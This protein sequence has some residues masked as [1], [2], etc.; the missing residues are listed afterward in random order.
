MITLPILAAL[1]AAPALTPARA[2]I[3]PPNVPTLAK[4][5]AVDPPLKDAPVQTIKA[6]MRVAKPALHRATTEM[7]S[8]HSHRKHR[9]RLSPT[10][11][12]DGAN[13]AALLKPTSH[14]FVNAVQ[15]YPYAQGALY[16]LYAA[17]ERISDIM[18]GSDESL[19]SVAAGDT[20]RWIIGDTVSGS[21]AGKRTHILVKPAAPGL[22]T[23]LVITTDKRS[24]HLDLVST[25][26]TAMAA[27]SWDYPE[28]TLLM[29]KRS[30][31]EAQ[32]QA[33]IASGLALDRLNFAYTIS[34]DT[35]P[36]RPLRAFDDGAQV[37]VEFSS[38]LGQG[39][40]PPL[41]VVGTNGEAEL[42]NYRVRGHYY[43]VD[44]L[45][46]QGELR[47]GTK[48]QQIVRISADVEGRARTSKKGRGQ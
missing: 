1:L 18:L 14:G 48:H 12:V 45:F 37:F 31:V 11:P 46:A 19:T 41:F 30:E 10:A 47:L 13:A 15:I 34:G 26:K 27:L 6:S 36:W 44:R 21:G 43:I 4:P 25:A 24:Y 35:P 29:L 33:P 17:P 7:P 39:E 9:A 23:N 8:N 5:T 16:Q 3:T 20:V 22:Q 2:P 40:A 38:A 32:A 28:N 42:V